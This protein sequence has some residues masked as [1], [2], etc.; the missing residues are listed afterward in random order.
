MSL[1][2][3][4]AVV[5]L[6]GTIT[7]C[8]GGGGEVETTP[9][10]DGIVMH[11]DQ[12]RVER[13]GREVF[14]R[15]ENNTTK[16]VT[17]VGFELTSPRL[18]DV[19]WTGSEE[20]GATY[21][22]DLEFDLPTGRCG[23]DIDAQVTL[24]YRVADGDLRRSTGSADDPYGAAALFA[25]R[26]CAQTT[27]TEAADISVGTPEVTGQ[28]PDSVLR[29]PVTLTPTG[30][31]GEVRFGGFGS[32]VLFQQ[33]AES[34]TGVDIPLDADSPPVELVMAVI[35][36][37]C[38]PHALAEDKVGTLFGVSVRATGL[39]DTASFFLPLDTAQRS[40]FFA[41]FRTYCGLA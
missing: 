31:A 30:E 19:R 36:A 38:D 29:L 41:F 13:K 28:G 1:R 34:P 25:D 26:D 15:V 8:G 6:A 10:P 40:A 3:L 12:S 9:L 14:L 35:P 23:T 7:A 11:V 17:V 33:T 5:L 21:E 27:L 22:T 32:T 24:T 16:P 20:I 2:P 37:R 18:E 39:A 4:L